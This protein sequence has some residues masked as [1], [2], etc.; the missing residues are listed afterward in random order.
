M[1]QD[2]PGTATIN[3]WPAVLGAIALLTLWR[4]AL[5]WLLPVTQDEAYYFDWARSLSWGYF[6]H[7]PGVA[8]LGIGVWLTPAS[9]LAARLGTL[10]AATLTLLVLARLYWRS[11]LRGRDDLL[12]A[13]LIAF[14]TVPG[15]ASG[16]ITT[17]DTVLALG[18][19]LAL[20]EAHAALTRD[21]RRWVTAGL[22]VGAGLLGKYTMALIG[23]VLLWAILR[24]DPR[25][26]RSPWP[27]LG[28]VLALAVFLPHLL[29]N[30]ENDWLTLRFQLGHGFSTETGALLAPSELPPPLDGAW[31]PATGPAEPPGLAARAGEVL[32]FLGT[33]GALWGL[34]ALPLL[35][36]LLPRPAGTPLARAVHGGL[37][38]AARTLLATAALFPLAFFALLASF[39][40]V[41]ANWPAMYVMAAAPFAAVALAPLRRWAYL[42]AVGN[43]VIVSLYAFHGATAALPLPDTQ[44]RVLRET[45]GFAELAAVAARLPGPVFA[46]R[47][48]TVAMLRFYQPQIR[49]T[50]WPGI[51]RPS[52]YLRGEIASATSIDALREGGGFWLITVRGVAPRLPGFRADPPRVLQDCPGAGLHDAVEGP[53]PCAKPLHTWRLVRYRPE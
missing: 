40:E 26:L 28:G 25:A 50:Q 43:L 46:D 38:P 48:Q 44:Q 23:P 30:A 51:N 18:W 39:S 47:Y 2:Q 53:S 3:P 37:D 49:A 9:A 32:A 4:L 52:E 42:A 41:E 13:V 5:A 7:P 36:A 22:A 35:A 16:L 31:A 6:D 29:W 17:P 20:H 11:G 19:A 14:A 27:W 24:R 12:L 33:Q 8:L 15:I 1:S 34:L 10:V 45:H 21:R